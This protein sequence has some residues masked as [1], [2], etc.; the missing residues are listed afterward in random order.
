MYK[1]IQNEE[2]ELKKEGHRKFLYNLINHFI[3]REKRGLMNEIE[4]LRKQAL[5][6]QSYV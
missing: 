6:K 4:L 1:L 5:R 2:T 3:S